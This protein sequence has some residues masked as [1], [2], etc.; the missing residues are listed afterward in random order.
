MNLSNLAALAER[1]R[2]ATSTK[3]TSTPK[4]IRVRRTGAYHGAHVPAGGIVLVWPAAPEPGSGFLP[5]GDAVEL[6]NAGD[7]VELTEAEIEAALD[8]M[9]REEA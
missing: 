7:A 8:A 1:R 9:E 2:L 6:V 5:A 4:A 3:P